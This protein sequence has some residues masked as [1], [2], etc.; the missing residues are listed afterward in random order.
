MNGFRAVVS[1]LGARAKHPLP[2]QSWHTRN[3]TP[4]Q[5]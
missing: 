2:A 5:H 1:L 4:H 3:G